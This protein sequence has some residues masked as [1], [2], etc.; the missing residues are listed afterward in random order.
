M[1]GVG[2]SCRSGTWWSGIDIQEYSVHANAFDP[3]PESNIKPLGNFKRGKCNRFYLQLPKHRET[4][5]PKW[6]FWYYLHLLTT[7]PFLLVTIPLFKTIKLNSI[8]SLTLTAY[9][10][11]SFPLKALIHSFFIKT[12]LAR[13][14][15]VETLEAVLRDK[16]IFLSLVMQETIF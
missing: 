13:E 10:N 8:I 12:C 6:V 2:G 5:Y 14:L 3:Y 1:A 15:F 11:S 16:M 9:V 4:W 7:Q